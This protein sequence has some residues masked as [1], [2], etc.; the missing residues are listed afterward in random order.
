MAAPPKMGIEQHALNLKLQDC[1]EQLSV[2]TEV[3]TDTNKSL[4]PA[5]LDDLKQI[6]SSSEAI[7]PAQTD[8]FVFISHQILSTISRLNSSPFF[9]FFPTRI[10]SLLFQFISCDS[11][12][13]RALKLDV[14]NS[15][16]LFYPFDELLASAINYYDK[17]DTFYFKSS[18]FTKISFRNHMLYRIFENLISQINSED[19]A[20]KTDL[21]VRNMWPVLEQLNNTAI[22]TEFLIKNN[23]YVL[24][25]FAHCWVWQF[26]HGNA[27]ECGFGLRKIFGK[28]VEIRKSVIKTSFPDFNPFLANMLSRKESALTFKKLFFYFLSLK[29]QSKS[30]PLATCGILKIFTKKEIRYIYKRVKGVTAFINI[31]RQLDQ[32]YLVKELRK[33]LKNGDGDYKI[34]NSINVLK[35]EDKDLYIYYRE[36]FK[37]AGDEYYV[38]SLNKSENTPVKS[39]IMIANLEVFSQAFND[40]LDKYF[41][42]NIKVKKC[43]NLCDYEGKKIVIM[44]LAI[45]Q[46]L[47]YYTSIQKTIF[48]DP[49]W[50]ASLLWDDTPGLADRNR[51]VIIN[52]ILWILHNIYSELN[53]SLKVRLS[54]RLLEIFHIRCFT[55]RAGLLILKLM[56]VSSL[57]NLIEG[58]EWPVVLKNEML[59]SLNCL[60]HLPVYNCEVQDNALTIVYLSYHFIENHDVESFRSVSDSLDLVFNHGKDA[61]LLILKLLEMADYTVQNRI[62]LLFDFAVRNFTNILKHMNGNTKGIA[63]NLILKMLRARAVLPSLAVPWIMS[64]Y[65]SG[66]LRRHFLDTMIRTTG[67]AL[68][69]MTQRMRDDLET[70]INSGNNDIYKV[71]SAVIEHLYVR[72]SHINSKNI[73][74]ILKELEFDDIFVCFILLRQLSYKPMEMIKYVCNTINEQTNNDD[75]RL[76][77]S[78]SLEFYTG[79]TLHEIPVEFLVF[80]HKNAENQQ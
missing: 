61:S 16:F 2:C 48:V 36:Y 52:N 51:N 59:A 71:I 1:S 38:L 32:R 75:I 80:E 19:S 56:N 26:E 18:S 72:L 42:Q 53:S 7:S 67:N 28:Y 45:S 62:S 50:I 70:M 73:K 30:H 44:S 54:R 78:K 35:L 40:E 34:F 43:H 12:F 77:A 66:Y 21:V 74:H 15:L 60:N 47:L 49:V 25:L 33:D 14:L 5:L 68:Q 9:G 3:F 39:G 64:C 63:T 10:H 41:V 22:F 69:L 57:K 58:G 79:S 23:S 4:F 6:Y 11:L 55:F 27:Q 76:L 37:I 24:L 17:L 31:F 8:Q 46:M 29:D 13:P 20:D 65:D